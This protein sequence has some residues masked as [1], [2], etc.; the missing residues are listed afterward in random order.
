MLTCPSVKYLHMACPGCG[1]QRSCI[2]LLKG[3]II[4]SFR[5]YPALIPLLV[6][7]AFTALHLYAK[8]TWGGKIIIAL[9]VAVVAIIAVHYI[10]KIVN[11]QI[12]V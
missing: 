1:L 11:H 8:F 6:L 4:E 7:C 2:A 5:L 3:H 10:Y 9:Q 12:F